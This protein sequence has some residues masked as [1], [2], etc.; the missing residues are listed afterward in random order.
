MSAPVL[1]NIDI[2]CHCCIRVMFLKK[3][4]E[5]KLVENSVGGRMYI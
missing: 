5:G 4:T 3:Y 2:K 1:P